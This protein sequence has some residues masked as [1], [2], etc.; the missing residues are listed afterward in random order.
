[1]VLKIQ[2]QRALTA[3]KQYCVDPVNSGQ[4]KATS[5]TRNPSSVIEN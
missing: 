5:P 1:M 4:H 3:C 2:T